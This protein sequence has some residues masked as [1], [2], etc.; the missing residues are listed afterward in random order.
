MALALNPNG[1]GIPGRD[2]QPPKPAKVLLIGLGVS[3]A[4][5]IALIGYLA[6]QKWTQPLPPMSPDTGFIVE[7]VPLTPKP[8]PPPPPTQKPPPAAAA[9]KLH[10]PVP[11][12]LETPPPLFA[13]PRII[14]EGPATTG[15]VTTL[16]PTATTPPSPPQPPPKV[17]TRAN[18]QRIPS[19]DEMARYYPESA[20]RRGLSG[21]VTLNCMVALNGTVR[22]CVVAAES[23]ADEGFGSAALKIS[24]FFKMTPQTENGDPVDGATVRIPIRFSAGA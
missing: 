2:N 15:P 21:Q 17:I 5:H 19:A 1:F 23:P 3:G 18:W 9:P 6:Y 14:A 4:L 10:I 20:Q 8:P 13:D 24:R 7:T 16:A 22:D 12:P 11:T